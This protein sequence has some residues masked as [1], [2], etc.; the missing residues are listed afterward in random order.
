M[1]A[2]THHSSSGSV[3]HFKLQD[4]RQ[5][6][7]TGNCPKEVCV[8]ESYAW[9]GTGESVNGVSR[10]QQEGFRKKSSPS[11]PLGL[12]VCC[13]RHTYNMAAG[14]RYPHFITQT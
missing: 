13:R 9:D 5:R 2:D 6:R 4:R 11:S 1:A 10:P 7:R 14:Q 8:F 3:A 12:D